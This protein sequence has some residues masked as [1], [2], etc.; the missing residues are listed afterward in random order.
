MSD[1]IVID[2]REYPIP[3]PEDFTLGELTIAEEMG[4]DPLSGKMNV[5]LIRFLVRLVKDRAGEK[6]DPSIIDHLT[7]GQITVE[8][9]PS[10]D[11]DPPTSVDSSGETS[12]DQATLRAS[13]GGQS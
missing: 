13:F 1:R 10:G 11:G 7:M 12:G 8:R 5:G 2:G 6:Y 9:S 4:A 3:A